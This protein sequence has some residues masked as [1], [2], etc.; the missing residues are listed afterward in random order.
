[1]S[2]LLLAAVLAVPPAQ[3]ADAAPLAS[4]DFAP[5]CDA[6]FDRW[7]DGWTRRRGPAFPH[8]VPA[9]LEGE[10]LTI[11]A[12][13]GAAAAYSPAVAVP[14]GAAVRLAGR[15]SCDG[16]D[17]DA[18]VLS[19][20]LL[21][22]ADRRLA[23]VLSE[24]VSGN[25]GGTLRIGPAPPASG[26]VRAVIGCHL[27]PG[28][29]PG[30]TGAAR[31]DDLTLTAE[32]HLTVAL[33]PP[34][35][36]AAVGG[37]VT[38]NVRVGG[39]GGPRDPGAAAVRIVAPSGETGA[40][41]VALRSAGTTA[42]GGAAVT[43]AEPGLWMLTAEVPHAGE[44]LTRAVTVVA[45]NPGDLPD[46]TVAPSRVGWTFTTAP[47]PADAG[48]LADAAAAG[49][50]GWVRWTVGTPGDAAFAA[51]LRAR[52]VRAAGILTGGAFGGRAGESLA[53]VLAARSDAAQAVA[54]VVAPLAADVRHWQL[55]A[56]DEPPP[57]GPPGMPTVAGLV[58]G[59]AAGVVTAG[60]PHTGADVPVVSGDAPAP[61]AAWR[62]VSPEANPAPLARSV[63]TALATGDGP[64]F[65]PDAF[66]PAA[67]LLT[68]A[69]PTARFP[70]MRTLAGLLG[71][72]RLLGNVAAPVAAGDEPPTAIAFDTPRGVAL[73]VSAANLGRTDVRL[74]GVPVRRELSGV[75]SPLPAGTDG[76]HRLAWGPTPHVL[77]GLDG[78]LLRFRLGVRFAGGGE[79]RSAAGPQ[80]LVVRAGNP[81]GAAV[82]AT[83]TPRVPVGWRI[84]PETAAISLNP[85]EVG[86]AAFTL[87]LPPHVSLGEHPVPLAVRLTG[88]PG[89]AL[90]VPRTARVRLPGFSLTV[91]DRP[92]PGGGWEVTPTLA[93]ALPPDDEPA[94]RCDLLVP[95]APRLSRQTA[96]LP[97]GSHA[98]S[99]RLPA[100]AAAG[101]TVWLRVS[102][103]G[104]DRVLNLKWPLGSPPA[105]GG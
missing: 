40:V 87:R 86:E 97:A 101:E 77:T 105:G 6:D 92:L 84:E 16:L 10:A 76:T 39:V 90:T 37:A 69:G 103:V 99:F 31:F 9:A 20:S 67:G 24:P 25:D 65:L 14:T 68:D 46:P 21:D 75:S 104:G 18:A 30:V 13:G 7:P 80:P 52:G 72:G 59:A 91:A 96:P 74:G 23:R 36:A 12:N 79:L 26:T 56:D 45:A 58:R 41:P 60:P 88:G 3:G 55:G 83:I 102:E 51:A 35:V 38:V 33:D 93:H 71:G 64:V 49:G 63:I 19:L 32:P 100:S 95:G 98:L 70:V 44:H 94:F 61:A 81:F 89:G 47:P 57:L 82:S 27:V 43:L 5:D 2:A 54:A 1:M 34:A 50:A 17:A 66:H 62:V 78:D 85:G 4:W 53:D 29:E 48:R 42:A 28:A 73:A 15:V 22:A 11:T 8:F